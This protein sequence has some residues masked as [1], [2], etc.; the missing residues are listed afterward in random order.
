[1]LAALGGL[2]AAGAAAE[3][4]RRGHQLPSLGRRYR[5]P[6]EP[7]AQTSRAAEPVNP[8]AADWWRALDEGRD[9]TR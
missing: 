6:V 4:A 5:S 1:M 7:T 2:L 3:V 8:E 9:P